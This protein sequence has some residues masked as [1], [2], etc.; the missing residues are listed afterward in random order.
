MDL[1]T[2]YMN[3]M[4]AVPGCCVLLLMVD[5]LHELG[6]LNSVNTSHIFRRSIHDIGIWG[7]PLVSMAPSVVF[8]VDGLNQMGWGRPCINGFNWLITYPVA[9]MVQSST[10]A[11]LVTLALEFESR[12]NSMIRDLF[13]QL[14]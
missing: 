1:P 6:S 11:C 8:F 13:S 12:C 14:L 10:P 9:P 3:M 5:V 4:I 2:E 7:C